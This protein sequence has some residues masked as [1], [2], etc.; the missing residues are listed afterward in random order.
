MHINVKTGGPKGKINQQSRNRIQAGKA[1]KKQNT[2][3][4][5]NLK[6]GTEVNKMLYIVQG[7]RHKKQWNDTDWSTQEGGDQ[8]GK[9]GNTY[10]FNTDKKQSLD[11]TQEAEHFN[12][13]MEAQKKPKQQQ[14]TSNQ[15]DKKYTRQKGNKTINE[16]TR[17]V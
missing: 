8:R 16:N 10:T 11:K 6:T 15:K 4:H 13:K 12:I 1:G 9:G 2:N 7:T 3:N 14:R 5:N 17:R